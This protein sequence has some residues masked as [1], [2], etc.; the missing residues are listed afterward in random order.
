MCCAKWLAGVILF[1]AVNAIVSGAFVRGT[2]FW[3]H[4]RSVYRFENYLIH[5][6]GV[7]IFANCLL[8]GALYASAL[9]KPDSFG[10]LPRIWKH[11]VLSYSSGLL[12][13]VS[14]V[15]LILVRFPDFESKLAI[16]AFPVFLAACSIICFLVGILGWV[17][18]AFARQ[19]ISAS[20][21]AVMDGT[22]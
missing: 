2:L 5:I 10:S 7:A 4:Q 9:A 22:Q 16:A 11:L 15:P 8:W 21:R 18:L 12:G 17:H 14:L 6:L 3:V 19:R 20:V 1:L 13:Y